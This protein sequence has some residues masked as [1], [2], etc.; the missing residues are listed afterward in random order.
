MSAAKETLKGDDVDAIKKAADDLR[1]SAAKL[2]EELY[3]KAAQES[4]AAG[5]E[6]GAGADTGAG[7]PGDPGGKD[8]KNVFDAE[9]KEKNQSDKKGEN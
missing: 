5:A 9:F 6:G 1:D 2:A 7:G 8:Q 4:Q 3:K